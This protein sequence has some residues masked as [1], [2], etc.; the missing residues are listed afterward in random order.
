MAPKY[1]AKFRFRARV[2]SLGENIEFGVVNGRQAL[3][4]VESPHLHLRPHFPLEAMR[5]AES[6]PAP[7]AKFEIVAGYLVH[8]DKLKSLIEHSATAQAIV[9]HEVKGTYHL[10]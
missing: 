7:H 10:Q 1:G 2:F 3:K 6:G 5:E 4:R 8:C 9:R